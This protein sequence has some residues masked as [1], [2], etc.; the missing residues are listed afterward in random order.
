MAALTEGVRRCQFAT[1]SRSAASVQTYC[2]HWHPCW[3]Q[4]SFCETTCESWDAGAIPAA[5]IVVGASHFIA[6][7]YV[8]K[9]HRC[10]SR[11]FVSAT[12]RT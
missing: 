1:S 10:V 11:R 5:S 12:I 2:N 9:G 3:T 8:D 7:Y 4:V 6:I